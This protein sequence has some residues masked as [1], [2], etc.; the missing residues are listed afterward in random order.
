MKLIVFLL[1]MRIMRARFYDLVIK[2]EMKIEYQEQ[3]LDTSRM[4]LN[5]GLLAFKY[6]QTCS[7]FTHFVV[8]QLLCHRRRKSGQV[9][10]VN[11][12]VGP[13]WQ[14]KVM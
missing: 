6:P 9:K 10:H 1:Y 4:K 14:I 13:G 12:P 11:G 5:E 2:A 8:G 7:N 3:A